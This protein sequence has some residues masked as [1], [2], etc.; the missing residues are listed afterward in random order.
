MAKTD[1]L[2]RLH[3]GK[4]PQMVRWYDPR[5]LIRVGIR[6][7]VSSVFGQ[8]ADQRLIQAA[9][10]ASDFDKVKSRYDFSDPKAADPAHRLPIDE[11]GAY[12][13][14]YIADIGDGFEATYTTAYLLALDNL[15]LAAPDGKNRLNLHHGSVLIMGGDQ[16]YPQASREEY[17]KR[18]LEPY[19]AAFDVPQPQRKLFAIPGNHDWYDGLAAFDSL[20][21][22]SRADPEHGKGTQIGGW[23]CQQ[24][25]SYWAMKLPY[26][27]WIWGTDIQFSKYLDGAQVTYFERMAGQM[28]PGDKL[29]ICL[30]EP[31]WLLHDFGVEDEEENFF[32]ITAIARAAGVEICAVIA[33]DWHNY[34]HYY[35]A[36]IDVHFLTA[37]GGGS[38]LHPTHVLKNE[39]QVAWPKATSSAPVDG[40]GPPATQW[41]KEHVDLR[42]KPKAKGDTSEQGKLFPA[43]GSVVA[44]AGTAVREFGEAVEKAITP[45]ATSVAEGGRPAPAAKPK[46]PKLYPAPWTSRLI[47]LGNLFFPFRNFAFA[48]GLG[49]IYWIIT[50]EYYSLVTQ[51]DISAGRIDAVGLTTNYW[52]VFKFTPFYLIQGLLVSI[53]LAIMLGGIWIALVSYVDAGNRQ[54]FWLYLR[55][56]VI[57]SLHWAAHV[58]VMFGLGLA[59]V[60][61][62]NQAHPAV[63]NFANSFWTQDAKAAEATVS[64]TVT[65]KVLEPLSEQRQR[66]REAWEKDTRAGTPATRNR[67]APPTEAIGGVQPVPGAA[68]NQLDSKAVRQLMGFLFYPLQM[69]FLGGIAGGFVWGLYWVITGLFFRMHAEEAFGALRNPNYRNFLRMKFERD[70]LTIYPIGLDKLPSRHA[71]AERSSFKR[72]KVPQNQPHLVSKGEIPVR[73]IEAP[74]VIEKLDRAPT[75]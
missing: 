46:E 19:R 71:W 2:A 73:L 18:L 32:H 8:Y 11:Q 44:E 67:A 72:A 59:F 49:L 14:D 13:I 12:W 55:K 74:I 54:G 25:R 43:P 15:R 4:L 50:W 36:S 23:Q 51:H 57:G 3:A 5:L 9:T 21:C 35:N 24:H 17:K 28:Q 48:M 37:G 60:Q 70:R 10:D 52:D 66:H 58:S 29:I 40:F 31:S 16:V 45:A 30:A 47:S 6:T 34:A 42:L 33:G 41:E 27:W 63:Y 75:S 7:M 64:G 53:P 20:F 61:F 56:F 65:R 68:G 69:I 39:I 1:T 22:A 38:F 62:N 26:N